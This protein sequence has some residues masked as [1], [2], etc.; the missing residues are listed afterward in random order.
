L[1]VCVWR[2]TRTPRARHLQDGVHTSRLSTDLAHPIMLGRHTNQLA[3]R[4]L[5]LNEHLEAP[6]LHITSPETWV[7]PCAIQAVS[8]FNERNT[9]PPQVEQDSHAP[10]T[11]THAPALKAPKW[12]GNAPALKAPKWIGNA[13]C[14][15]KKAQYYSCEA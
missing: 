1:S 3:P 6:A 11:H 13:S 7:K 5:P 9:L 12:I 15:V 2:P 14:A 8:V 4:A 10:G